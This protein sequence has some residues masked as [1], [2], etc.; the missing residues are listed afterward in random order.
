MNNEL[1]SIIIMIF[2]SLAIIF[3]GKAGTKN[4]LFCYESLITILS[5]IIAVS[6][7]YVTQK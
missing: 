2:I 5:F 7:L 4:K 3:A 6:I 1:I